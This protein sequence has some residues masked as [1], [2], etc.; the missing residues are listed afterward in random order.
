[1]LVFDA[2]EFS[3]R[4]LS[5]KVLLFKIFEITF[6][7]NVSLYLKLGLRKLFEFDSVFLFYFLFKAKSGSFLTKH[8][9]GYD[10]FFSPSH[11]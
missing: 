3:F 4:L 6:I 1:M 5:G 10:V 9:G 11:K 2:L 7:S 8:I